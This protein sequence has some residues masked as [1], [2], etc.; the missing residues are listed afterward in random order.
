MPPDLPSN[1][2]L[3]RQKTHGVKLFTWREF[4]DRLGLGRACLTKDVRFCSCHPCENKIFLIR[5]KVVVNSSVETMTESQRIEGLPLPLG[6]HTAIPPSSL[7]KGLGRDH[8][9]SRILNSITCDK[10]LLSQQMAEMH[11]IQQGAYQICEINPMVLR[12][13]QLEVHAALPVP[14]K[15][16]RSHCVRNPQ[17]LNQTKRLLSEQQATVT[18]DGLQPCE[19]KSRTGFHDAIELLRYAAIVCG[20]DILVLSI[21]M[22][23]RMVSFL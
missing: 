5:C 19:V 6:K 3:C 17:Q 16:G 2:S 10:A 11:D 23:Q 1:A 12:I 8:M 22:V 13:S 9:A 7:S 14:Y 4:L 15:K 18:I 21:I 20:G